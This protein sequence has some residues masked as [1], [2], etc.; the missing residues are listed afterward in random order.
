MDM[1]TDHVV[2]DVVRGKGS[3][4]FDGD[5]VRILGDRTLLRIEYSGVARHTCSDRALCRPA[6]FIDA[7][8]TNHRGGGQRTSNGIAVTRDLL[9]SSG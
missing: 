2:S 6:T 4:P 1:A 8:R 9:S 5:V 7:F 3:R